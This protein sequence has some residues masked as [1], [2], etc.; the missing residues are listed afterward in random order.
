MYGTL[1]SSNLK[2]KQNKC[3][4]SGHMSTKMMGSGREFLPQILQDIRYIMLER[5]YEMIE[6]MLEKE[7][8][9]QNNCR[10]LDF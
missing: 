7:N 1:V 10:K 6:I 9:S 8:I 5:N 2:A 4:V 3:C